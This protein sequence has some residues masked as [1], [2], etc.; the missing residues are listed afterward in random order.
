MRGGETTT[1][2]TT[3]PSRRLSSS[4]VDQRVAVA[5]AHRR[6]VHDDIGR[7]R[8]GIRLVPGDRVLRHARP[9]RDEP[10]ELGAAPRGPVHDRDPGGTGQSAGLDGD[11][12]GRTP[13]P[14]DDSS[15]AGSTTAQRL[16]EALAVGVVADEP[17]GWPR[18][19]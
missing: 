14:D 15:P 8:H 9:G 11:R 12:P 2:A 7:G 19:C 5:E 10:G 17:S 16:D 1:S 3:R 13:A 6:R 4:S 18:R